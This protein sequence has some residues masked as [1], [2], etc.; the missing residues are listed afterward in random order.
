MNPNEF[1]Y[2][3]EKMR[4][5]QRNYFITRDTN[6]LHIAKTLEKEVDAAIK[7]HNKRDTLQLD[8]APTSSIPTEKVSYAPTGASNATEFSG[9]F[10]L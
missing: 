3:V 7:S 8:F 5:A 4:A 6:M 9:G 10:T 1:I 2:L